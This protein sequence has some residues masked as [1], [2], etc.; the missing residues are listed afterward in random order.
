MVISLSYLVALWKVTQYHAVA[1]CKCLSIS[2][3]SRICK[4]V[5]LYPLLVDEKGVLDSLESM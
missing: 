1:K 4:K 2:I 3:I 5:F